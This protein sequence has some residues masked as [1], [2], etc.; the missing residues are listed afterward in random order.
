MTIVVGRIHTALPLLLL[1][2]RFPPSL[3]DGQLCCRLT[4]VMSSMVSQ[5]RGDERQTNLER[6][7]GGGAGRESGETGSIVGFTD[8]I[9]AVV[10]DDAHDFPHCVSSVTAKRGQ[11]T[12]GNLL[13]LHGVTHCVNEI[14]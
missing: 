8:K 6:G 9:D 1:L 4:L 13:V 2:S 3:P 10:Y 12:L 14:P 11:P 7:R 5:Y